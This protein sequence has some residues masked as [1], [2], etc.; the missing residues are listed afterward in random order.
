MTRNTDRIAYILKP[1]TVLLALLLA[2]CSSP[3]PTP[4]SEAPVVERFLSKPA[5]AL[6]FAALGWERI[7]HHPY[8]SAARFRGDSALVIF[9]TGEFMR[10]DDL[11]SSWFRVSTPVG[12]EKL[13][14]ME[15]SADGQRGLIADDDGLLFATEDGGRSWE[16]AGTIG[17]DSVVVA[18]FSPDLS[19]VIGKSGC[20]VFIG[21]VGSEGV[22]EPR[23]V[24]EPYR[25]CIESFLIESDA[26]WALV[27]YDEITAQAIFRHSP[28]DSTWTPVC[29]QFDLDDA[30]DLPTCKTLQASDEFRVWSKGF[31]WDRY[32]SIGDLVLYGYPPPDNA[33]LAKWVLSGDLV[34]NESRYWAFNTSGVVYSDD[35]TSWTAVYRPPEF[36]KRV[37]AVDDNGMPVRVLG[38]KSIWYRESELVWSSA[39]IPHETLHLSGVRQI[40]NTILGHDLVSRMAVS[41]DDGHTWE[42]LDASGF[43]QQSRH[44]LLSKRDGDYALVGVFDK[45][46][47]W[48]QM[49]VVGEAGKGIAVDWTF[50]ADPKS[51]V[52]CDSSCWAVKNGEFLVWLPN[53]DG[54]I[55]V[56]ARVAL[57]D[58]VLDAR[59]DGVFMP[60]YDAWVSKDRK[61]IAILSDRDQLFVSMDGGQAWTLAGTYLGISEV[62][63]LATDHS[64]FVYRSAGVSS[65]YLYRFDASGLRRLQLTQEELFDLCVSDDGETVFVP[66]TQVRVSLDG[67][68]P[69]SISPMQSL[70]GCYITDSLWWSGREVW[71]RKSAAPD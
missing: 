12:P 16:S 8:I 59:G 34:S 53:I 64:A 1:G 56:Q 11:G 35:G 63:S 32:H 37:L 23:L 39:S 17:V 50:V 49:Y 26:V 33:Q 52:G 18:R 66:S 28:G 4:P 65:L 38:F 36:P 9:N 69:F 68:M 55:E 30:V 57:P 5:P 51:A 54:S 43:E 58:A 40:G 61:L 7:E 29:E 67:E 62:T 25:T 60:I 44:R 6:D 48:Q 20:R 21:E 70:G 22:I 71:R 42:D 24:T 10:I 46:W 47:E 2:A 19:R 13:A 14:A 3:P 27:D 15:F 45:N 41:Y 31:E